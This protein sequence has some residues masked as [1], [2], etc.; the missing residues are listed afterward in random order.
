MQVG[1]TL[2]LLDLRLSI[3]VWYQSLMRRLGRTSLSKLTS[4]LCISFHASVDQRSP[5]SLI[6]AME[7][8]HYLNQKEEYPLGSTIGKRQWNCSEFGIK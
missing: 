6:S 8:T 5:F 4:V 1:V 3:C 2:N 7:T